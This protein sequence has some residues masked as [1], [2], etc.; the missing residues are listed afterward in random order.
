MYP[1][2]PFGFGRIDA[3]AAV[4]VA[5]QTVFRNGFETP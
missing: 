4:T 2:T 3:L 5:N 1:T